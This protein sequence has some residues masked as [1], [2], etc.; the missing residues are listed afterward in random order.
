MEDDRDVYLCILA[1]AFLDSKF[2]IQYSTESYNLKNM[3]LDNFY[4]KKLASNEVALY[5]IEA[6]QEFYLK[7]SRTEGFPYIT[8]KMCT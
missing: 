5:Q 2:S 3:A 6:T 7:V 1:T 8:T 4:I